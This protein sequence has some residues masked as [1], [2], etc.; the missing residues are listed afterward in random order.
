MTYIKHIPASETLSEAY[1]FLD[2]PADETVESRF[3]ESQRVV[4][5]MWLG[6]WPALIVEIPGVSGANLGADL[7]YGETWLLPPPKWFYI[8]VA[9]RFLINR[10][11]Y[12]LCGDPA[13]PGLKIYQSAQFLELFDMHERFV[14]AV[15]RPTGDMNAKNF[16]SA[17][18]AAE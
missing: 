6:E 13:R 15:L 14:V 17:I 9:N 7:L 3:I 5:A 4:E 16:E 11:L 18:K 8:D 1:L 2:E 10:R 12:Q